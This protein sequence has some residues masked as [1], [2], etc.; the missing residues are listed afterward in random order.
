MKAGRLLS[1][2][3]NP[4][5]AGTQGTECR[6][7]FDGACE[8]ETLLCSL[9]VDRD[10]PLQRHGESLQKPPIQAKRTQIPVNLSALSDF[11]L[12]FV[13]KRKPLIAL[14]SAREKS[15][16]V[17]RQAVVRTVRAI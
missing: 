8:E 3:I 12:Q 4:L 13:I 9:H 16:S 17:G 10:L 2:S 11:C 7:R 14:K 1:A 6:L 5:G 15:L